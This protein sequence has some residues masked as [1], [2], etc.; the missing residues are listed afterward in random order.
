MTVLVQP[1]IYTDQHRRSLEKQKYTPE[2]IDALALFNGLEDA[3]TSAEVGQ[4]IC[5]YVRPK[6]TRPLTFEQWYEGNIYCTTRTGVTHV[7][8][9]A[10]RVHCYVLQGLIRARRRGLRLS[11]FLNG[12][13]SRNAVQVA[14]FAEK[15]EVQFPEFKEIAEKQL[16][17]MDNAAARR[18]AAGKL[19]NP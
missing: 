9:G 19:A 17:A 16:A 6:C 15:D 1:V 11:W 10:W 7:I 8:I 4:L 18:V 14:L 12:Q 3:K 2:E 13:A 5:N